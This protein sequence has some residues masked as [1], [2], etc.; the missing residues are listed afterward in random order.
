MSAAANSMAGS[1]GNPL[2]AVCIGLQ[3]GHMGTIGP[4]KPGWIHTFR[5][6]EGVE[7][8]AY[9]EDT[10]TEKLAEGIRKSRRSPTCIC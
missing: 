8:V 6:L 1:G 10:A 3:H 9:C 5:Q 7:V 2:K 4:V